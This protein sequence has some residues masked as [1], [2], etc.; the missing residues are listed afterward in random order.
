MSD[1]KHF[2]EL[3]VY[4]GQRFDWAQAGGGN[5]SVQLEDGTFYVKASGV[6]LTEVTEAGG[7]VQLKRKA[8]LDIFHDKE[9][10]AV[11]DARR[12]EAPARRKLDEAVLSGSGRPSIEA[13]MHAL[14]GKYTLHTHP[15]GVNIMACRDG[16]RESFL[17]I[18]GDCLCVA[19]ATPGFPLALALHKAV[20][21]YKEKHHKIPAVTFIQNHGLIVTGESVSEVIG[22]AEQVSVKINQALKRSDEPY[23]LTTAVSRL[24][25]NVAGEHAV[26]LACNDRTVNRLAAEDP[27]LL[28]QPP[29]SPDGITF[30]GYGAV[31]L[32]DLEDDGPVREYFNRHRVLPRVLAFGGH[33]FCAAASLRKAKEVED[34]LRF[35]LTVL[36]EAKGARP[37]SKDEQDYLTHWEAEKYRQGI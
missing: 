28:A 2:I 33:V 1:L 34:V 14:F 21:K 17:R 18:F 5:T 13:Y 24:L 23:N 29:F 12:Q 6:N 10:L 30:C 35:H 37:L 3:S 11:S 32:S 27:G 16:W 26:T 22:T 25:A 19:Y 20:D 31:T 4:A 15:V 36:S 9:V 8:V 7:F